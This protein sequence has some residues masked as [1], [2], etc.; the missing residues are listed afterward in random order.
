[1][2]LIVAVAC[3]IT[4][5]RVAAIRRR[6]SGQ[7]PP[8]RHVDLKRADHGTGHGQA[9]LLLDSSPLLGGGEKR[10]AAPGRGG[11]H[12][13]SAMTG[14]PFSTTYVASSDAVM[15]PTFRTAWTAPAGT[16]NAS[17]ALHVL[18]RWPAA[19]VTSP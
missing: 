19:L 8:V 15:L 5:Q 4:S 12:S 10:M 6:R 1:M 16:V 7:V 13:A 18:A 2:T 14:F 11:A 9:P 17:P 3:R